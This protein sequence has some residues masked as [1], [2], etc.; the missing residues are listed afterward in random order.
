MTNT[1]IIRGGNTTPIR[2]TRYKRADA[3]AAVATVTNN[4]PTSDNEPVYLFIPFKRRERCRPIGGGREII[5][6]KLTRSNPL[7]FPRIAVVNV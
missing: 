4:I 7:E 2:Y 3:A 5:K 6:E 1:F